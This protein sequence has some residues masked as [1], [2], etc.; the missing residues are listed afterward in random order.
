MFEKCLNF[1][2][3]YHTTIDKVVLWV[4]IVFVLIF[5]V[6]FIAKLAYAEKPDEG[7]VSTTAEIVETTTEAT[8]E[9][10]TTTAVTTSVIVTEPPKITYFN[11]PLSK[12]LQEYIFEL[13]ANYDIK[14]EVVIA[15]IKKESEFNTS[16]IGDHGNSYGLMQIQPK[17]HQARMDSLGCTD[18]L[19]PYQ[20][21]AVGINLL[22]ELFDTGNSLEWVL[23]AYN[24]GPSYANRKAANGELSEYARIVLGYIKTFEKGR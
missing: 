18:L 6:V 16:T 23:M 2:Y 5:A 20:N 21:V 1:Y 4:W 8:T 12:D 10:V 9:E 17:W 7:R 13:C 15:V 24:G 22:A 11:V 14:P 3:K 19:D